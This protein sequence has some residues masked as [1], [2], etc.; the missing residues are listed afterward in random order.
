MAEKGIKIVTPAPK[1]AAE[2]AD[3]GARM[4]DEWAGK[5]GPEGAAILKAFRGK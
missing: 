3:I 4:A 5:A 2:L 1:F